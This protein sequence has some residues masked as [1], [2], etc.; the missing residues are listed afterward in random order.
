M[1][2][3]RNEIAEIEQGLADRENNLLKN[4]PHTHRLLVAEN[5]DKPYPKAKA[6]FP[7]PDLDD[8]KYWP[9]VARIDNAHG[10]KHLVCS[11]PPIEAYQ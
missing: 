11:C 8:D 10:D 7:M 2:Q 6:F 5:W 3:I 4:A 1:I 9:P